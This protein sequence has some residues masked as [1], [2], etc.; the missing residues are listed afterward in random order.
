MT[1]NSFDPNYARSFKARVA[2][3]TPL[4]NPDSIVVKVT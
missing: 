1:Y 2:A 3:A 4:R